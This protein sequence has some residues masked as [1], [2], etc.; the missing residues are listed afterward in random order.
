M[1]LVSVGLL[2]VFCFACGSSGGMGQP[3][4]QFPSK[5][6]LQEVASRPARVKSDL[7]VIE[8]DRW[9]LETP[10]PPPNAGYPSENE[11]DA[12]VVAAARNNPSVRAAPELRCAAI[13]TARF[14]TQN[15]GYPE[16]GL[17]R[18]LLGRCGSPL[19]VT[20]LETL[21]LD[22]PD[23]TSDAD[24]SKSL[25]ARADEMIGR[26]AGQA[27]QE[28]G[29]GFA[30]S[31]GRA[32]MIAYFGTPRAR[33]QQFSPLIQGSSLTVSGELGR[34]V[35]QVLGFVNQNEYGVQLCE[36]DRSVGLPGFR[37]SCGVAEGDQI[38]RI[39]VASRKAN[40]VL[41]NVNLQILARRS[42]DAGLVYEANRTPTGPAAN[43]KEFEKTLFETLNGVR[44][45][46]GVRPLQFEAQ[47][48][49]ANEKLVPHFFEQMLQGNAEGADMI[50]LGLLAGW[51]VAGMIRDGGIYTGLVAT[52]RNPGRWLSYALESPLGRWVLLDAGMS[53][54][55]VG[56]GRLEPSGSLAVVTTYA[57]FESTDHKNDE[58]G[59]FN[60]LA[61]VRAAKGIAPPR[62][63]TSS[64]A[65][66]T[67]LSRVSMGL[68]TTTEAMNQ[69]LER[70]AHEQQRSVQGYMLETSDL[71]HLPFPELMLK[72]GSI[73]V[74]V[75]V[76]HYKPPGGAWGQYAVL[77][78][79][80]DAP[81]TATAGRAVPDDG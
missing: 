23:G 6:K 66:Q 61:K 22:V 47:Q 39:E 19:G 35:E 63:A 13:E 50:G 41:M 59:V 69:A 75:G 74:E 16:D 45:R 40:Q 44:A 34:D 17:R 73:E 55:A 80:Y 64:S 31:N 48:S 18:F 68:A 12:R 77:F 57:F 25:A 8:V 49:L 37:M 60:E 53:R 21:T 78:A 28:F 29:V 7:K 70:L 52:S 51:D 72:S 71:K 76:T 67:A 65:M 54:A 58:T 14:Y 5:D 11:W 1:R 62:R 9:Q 33:L 81:P 3:V 56:A 43:A 27:G 38:A 4:A 2:S 79:I 24:V 30:R 15:G 36:P 26:H 20:S 32:A 46:A 42:D 10:V